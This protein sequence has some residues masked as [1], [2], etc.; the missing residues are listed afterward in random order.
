MLGFGIF[1]GRLIT[2]EGMST[3][4]ADASG[5]ERYVDKSEH[6]NGWALRQ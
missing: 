5:S 6:F 3:T 4:V 1:Q 2:D